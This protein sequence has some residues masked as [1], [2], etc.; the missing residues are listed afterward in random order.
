VREATTLEI[1]PQP[2]ERDA[3]LLENELIRTLR[4]P[5][6]VDGAFYFLYPAVG[7]WQ[8]DAQ[9]LFCLTTSMDAWSG[10]PF[11]W[12]GSFRSRRTKDAFEA[13]VNLLAHLGHIESKASLPKL[14][15]VRG[16]RVIGFRRLDPTLV[17]SLDGFWAGDRPDTL[18]L[19]AERLL[20]RTAARR[21]APEIEEQL[22]LLRS[23]Y[24]S[25]IVKLRAAIHTTGRSEGFVPQQQRDSLF[26][27]SRTVPGET[28]KAVRV[29]IENPSPPDTGDPTADR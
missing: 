1:R 19:L 9:T 4:P 15:Y 3:L 23:F 21:N 25:D 7:I 22:K 26:I 27:V 2:S 13:M 24:A 18:A 5:F 17:A 14:P 10:V 6:N 29:A 20:D 11:G 8:N 28:P 16:S 12:H